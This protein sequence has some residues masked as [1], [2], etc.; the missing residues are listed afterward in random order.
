MQYIPYPVIDMKKTVENIQRIR[1]NCGLEV[2]DVQRFLGLASPCG[3]YLWQKG[4]SLPSVDH[5]CAISKLFRVSM[6]DIIVLKDS[7]HPD[8]CMSLADTSQCSACGRVL[9]A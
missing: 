5:L 9:P 3:I 4:C 1:M 2:R 7:Y 8:V 6:D